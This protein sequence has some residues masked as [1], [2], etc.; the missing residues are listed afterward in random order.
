MA[1]QVWSKTAFSNGYSSGSITDLY[2]ESEAELQLRLLEEKK[3]GG[4]II[5]FFNAVKQLLKPDVKLLEFGPGRGSWT[6]GL[7]SVVTKGEIHTIDLQDIRPWVQD[8]IE[9]FGDRFFTHQV[10]M[11][12]YKYD[13]FQ[14]DYFDFFFSFGV[15]CHMNIKDIEFFLIKLKK[16][17]KKNAICVAQY[18]DWQKGV[19]YCFDPIGKKYNQEAY[20]MLNEEYPFEFKMLQAKSILQKVPILVNRYILDKYSKPKIPSDCS[21]W[22]RNNR[23]TMNRLLV[24]TG[25]QVL[26]ID[27]EH[28][29]RDSVAI[30]KA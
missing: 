8:L 6:R 15:F 30:F 2:N 19:D 28:F 26:K 10:E 17:M 7:F 9:K 11:G 18:S 29:K 27:T 16:K 25:F 22:V 3:L 14:D 21:W 12:D 5:T 20:K 4:S 1:E 23:K 24:K 13:F